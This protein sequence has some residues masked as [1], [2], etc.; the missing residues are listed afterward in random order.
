MRIVWMPSFICALSAEALAEPAALAPT[1][2][3]GIHVAWIISHA[4]LPFDHGAVCDFVVDAGAGC[5]FEGSRSHATSAS[6]TSATESDVRIDRTLP[7]SSAHSLR[8]SRIRS[9]D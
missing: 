6:V 1:K 9:G 3:S 8:E 7:Q 2:P 5:A 4:V